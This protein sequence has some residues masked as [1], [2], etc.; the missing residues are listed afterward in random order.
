MSMTPMFGRVFR[1]GALVL[2]PL[3]VLV[4]LLMGDEARSG[5][6]APGVMAGAQTRRPQLTLNPT[7]G[8]VGT[9]LTATLSGVDNCDDHFSVG[10]NAPPRSP[11]RADASTLTARGVVPRGKEPGRHLLT[12]ACNGPGVG[13]EVEATFTVT[14]ATTT[15][16]TTSPTSGRTTVPPTTGATISPTTVAPDGQEET[17]NGAPIG[18]LIGIASLVVLIAVTALA[19]W[20]RS[21]RPPRPPAVPEAEPA[22]P[23]PTGRS[24]ER[25]ADQLLGD[26]PTLPLVAAGPA[27]AR[28]AEA[29]RH[30]AVADPLIA[31]MV[32]EAFAAEA[33]FGDLLRQAGASSRALTEGQMLVVRHAG[34]TRHD[35]VVLDPGLASAAAVARPVDLR[36]VTMASVASRRPLSWKALVER[37]DAKPWAELDEATVVDAIAE[38]S[39]AGTFGLVLAASPRALLTQIPSPA[40]PI[41]VDNDEPAVATAGAVVRTRDGSLAVTTALH[42]VKDQSSVSVAGRPARLKSVHEPTDSCVIEVDGPAV[43]EHAL[44]RAGPLRALSPRQYEQVVFDGISSGRKTTKVTAWD[45]SILAVQQFVGSKVY[46]SPDTVPGDSGSALVDSSDHI[47]GFAVYRSAF[48]EPIE[49]SAWVWADQVF[50]AHDLRLAD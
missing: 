5:V 12:A 43:E 21:R 42:A 19:L 34:E 35:L 8:P 31:T 24:F 29:C 16:V 26:Q 41:F 49:Y 17:T 37:G 20:R 1:G 32:W 14:P 11:F 3:V 23:L 33:Q 50:G 39:E 30:E 27:A 6:A 10:W 25:L 7:S 2:V 47:I 28:L 48:G 18:L 9:S 38:A 40:W 44:G 46:T 4:T 45:L 36:G 13:V 22:A 15:S